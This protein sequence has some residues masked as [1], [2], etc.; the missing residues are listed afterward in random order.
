MLFF[1]RKFSSIL[2]F[3]SLPLLFLPKLNLISVDVEETAGL[4]IDD[5]VLLF[6]GVILMWAH[7]LS[8]QK[9]YQVEFWILSITT[10]SIFSFLT[11]RLLV[12]LGILA[13]DAKIF[14]SLRLLEYFLFFYIGAIAYQHFSDRVI[15]KAFFLWN[16]L[17]MILQKFQLAGGIGA[18]GIR[19]I[20][21]AGFRE[22]LPFLQKWAFFS[23]CFFVI[24]LLMM[25]QN[26]NLSIYFPP[27]LS[28]I[29]YIT[30]IFMDYSVYS[31]FLLF[32]RV[33]ASQLLL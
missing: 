4:R 32:L 12:S 10:F 18:L 17:L 33:I 22:L 31:V 7:I 5:F 25:R 28:I 30:C 21:R 6:I 11:N 26:Q 3:I 13:M 9:L 2:L 1:D 24:S 15:V 23:T 14:Y 16:I 27:L 29:F 19:M 20:Y 8:R